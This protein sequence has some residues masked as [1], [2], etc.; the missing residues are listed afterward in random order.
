MRSSPSVVPSFDV[1]VYIVLDDFSELGRAYLE[2]DEAHAERE[3]IVSNLL[4]GEY[5]KPFRFAFNTGEGCRA[6]CLRTWH[7]RC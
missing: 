2:T 4:G 1:T 5:R 3:T 7:G 6:T